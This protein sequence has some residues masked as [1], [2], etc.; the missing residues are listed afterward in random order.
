MKS[1]GSKQMRPVSNYRFVR[2]IIQDPE[3]FKSQ[4]LL[5]QAKRGGELV[6]MLLAAEKVVTSLG[7]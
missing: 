5:T 1:K 7:D 6:L 2:G 4:S 3:E